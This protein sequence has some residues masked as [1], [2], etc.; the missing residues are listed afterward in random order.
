[1]GSRDGFCL[2]CLVRL[3]LV[4]LGVALFMRWKKLRRTDIRQMGDFDVRLSTT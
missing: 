3:L 4:V 1:M 2:A